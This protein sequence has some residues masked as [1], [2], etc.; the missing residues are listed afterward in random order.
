VKSAARAADFV[1]K[2]G[3]APG[4]AVVKVGEDRPPPLYVRNKRKACE[5]CGIASFAH[6]CPRRLR[7]RN[8][9]R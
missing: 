9:S 4:V 3:R 1:S 5:E 8:C 6:D 7:V 2:Y